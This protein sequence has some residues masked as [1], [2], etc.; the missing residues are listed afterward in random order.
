[1]ERGIACVATTRK[2]A[3]ISCFSD[4]ER[5]AY[6]IQPTHMINCAAFTRVDDAEKEQELAYEVNA[7]GPG[8]LGSLARRLQ[9]KIVHISTDYVFGGEGAEPYK[10]TD[11]VNPQNVYGKTK[12]EGEC[13]L[14][15]ENP[16]ACIVR[17]S[18]LYGR[19]G[20]NFISSLVQ[21]LTT[22]PELN[23]VEDQKGKPTY[24][25]DLAEVVLQLVDHS[26]LFHFAN[27]GAM[28]R[29][30]IAK[31]VLS[32]MRSLSRE[33]MCDKICPVK[34]ISF[35]TPAKRPAYSVLDTTKIEQV[36]GKKPRHWEETLQEYLC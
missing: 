7:R 16:D 9:A 22:N 3:D 12:W 27:E 29:Y 21:L 15:N 1:M 33:V 6:A 13:N 32:H 8:Y 2:E 19:H 10:E 35:P 26:G 14:L 24:F 5:A 31:T 17:T 30:E 36:L 23:V 34:S 20:K 11:P 25:K 4:L 18:W 28:S